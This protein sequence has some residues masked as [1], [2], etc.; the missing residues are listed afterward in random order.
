[1]ID[2]TVVA[3]SIPFPSGVAKLPKLLGHAELHV[4]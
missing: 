4:A 2:S 3:P 1:M